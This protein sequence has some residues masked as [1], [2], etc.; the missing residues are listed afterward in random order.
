MVGLF[1][2]V[3][4]FLLVFFVVWLAGTHDGRNY[5]KYTIYFY[6]AVGGL[7]DGAVVQYRGVEVG[8]V[9]EVRLSPGQ[10]QL[11]KV[12]IEV[13]EDTPITASSEASLAT[14]GVTGLAF[15]NLTTPDGDKKPPIIVKGEKYP[16]IRGKGATLSKL[17]QDIPEISEQVLEIS[18]KLNDLL[19]KDNVDNLNATIQNVQQVSANLNR[20][21]TDQNVQNIS[22]TLQN[23]STA[24]ETLDQTIQKFQHTADQIDQTAN[25]LN[26]VINRNKGN[27]D[28]F[29]GD[30][31]AQITE[32]TKETKDMARSM[33][34]LADK[35]QQNPSQLIYK[36]NYNGVEVPK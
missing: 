21:M 22:T 26:D 16:V 14:L 25:N 5:N 10:A 30:G 15:I 29:A 20:L 27:I 18:K 9:R 19:N 23:V 34:R 6:D 24:S 32:M 11:I 36:P 31:L 17:F 7:Q 2:S 1:V 33:R 35:L 12:D 3:A 28:R 8:R 4:F 13:D